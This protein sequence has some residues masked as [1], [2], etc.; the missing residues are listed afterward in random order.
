MYWCI[1][2]YVILGLLTSLTIANVEIIEDFLPGLLYPRESETREASKIFI[3]VQKTIE[4]LLNNIFTTGQV[5]R[6][7]LG[8]CY[9]T[10]WKFI[11]RLS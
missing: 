11:Q 7:T 4:L 10:N 9:F 5:F 3:N 2:I 6:W 8:L 1:K